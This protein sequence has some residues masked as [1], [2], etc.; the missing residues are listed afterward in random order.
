MIPTMFQHDQ[1]FDKLLDLVCEHNAPLI[2]NVI[3]IGTLNGGTAFRFAE[4][5][6]K[7]IT[8]DLPMG[9]FGGHTHG[10]TWEKAQ[11]RSAYLQRLCPDILPI[12]GDSHDP[13]TVAAV[14]AAL[15]DEK[16]DLLFIDGDHS[17]D[18]VRQDL[19]TYRRFIRPRGLV[20]FHDINTT[21]YHID[22]GC[23]VHELWAELKTKHVH[24]EFTVG[25]EWGGIGVLL[26]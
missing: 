14:E 7:V 10:Y 6:G 25:H 2:P 1:E 20:A 3:E 17:R 5:G 13:A 19:E 22:N 8:I 21:K 24:W 4:L 16:F 26:L 23:F 9:E 12:L 18:G 11:K 15:E